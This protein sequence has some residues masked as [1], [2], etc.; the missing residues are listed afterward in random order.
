MYAATHT[1]QGLPNS[2]AAA[3]DSG[4]VVYPDSDGAPM[5]DNTLQFAWI[6]RLREN[7]D[8]MLPDFVAG[9]H[10]WYPVAGRNKLRAAP[11][12]MVCLGRPKG[13]RGSYRQFEEDGVPP[14]VVFEVLS[15]GNRPSEM[16]RKSVFYFRYGAREFIVIDPDAEDGYA[17]WLNADGDLESVPSLDGWTSPTLGIRFE[18]TERGLE[19]FRPDGTRFLDFREIEALA[20]AES[21]RADREAARATEAE[22]RHARLAAK[23]AALGIAPDDD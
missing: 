7:L 17:T 15:P 16:T 5:A 4:V 18:Q 10:L 2:A 6:V 19:V 23:L 3:A 1:P 13:Y 22:A 8:A 21:A 20:K 9:D 11:D 12:V 14:T